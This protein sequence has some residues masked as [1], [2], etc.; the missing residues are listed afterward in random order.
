MNSSSCT[1]NPEPD[2]GASSSEEAWGRTRWSPASTLWT[3]SIAIFDL[4]RASASVEAIEMLRRMASCSGP[5][6]MPSRSASPRYASKISLMRTTDS[7][8]VQILD[9][10]AAD[11]AAEAVLTTVVHLGG[12]GCCRGRGTTRRLS[13]FQ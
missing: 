3:I 4:S 6:I 11:L 8:A 7:K 13:K 5:Q 2:L 10:R 12:E 1:E 9:R